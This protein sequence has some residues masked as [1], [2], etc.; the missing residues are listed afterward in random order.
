[1]W[2]LERK[3]ES[4][5]FSPR[6]IRE[7]ALRALRSLLRFFALITRS[8]KKLRKRKLRSSRAAQ[9]SLF[10]FLHHD[11]LVGIPHTFALV[12]LRRAIPANLRRHLADLLLV[13]AAHEDLRLGRRLDGHAV[14][15]IEFHRMAESQL[16]VELAALSLRT[17]PDADQIQLLL[18]TIG[19]TLHHIVYERA[20][21][22][23]HRGCPARR[24]FEGQHALFVLHFHGRVEIHRQFALGPLDP[25]LLALLVEFDALRQFDRITG[26]SGHIYFSVRPRCTALRRRALRAA[27]VNHSSRPWTCS[28]SR[29]R[30]RPVLA[31]GRKRQSKGVDPACLRG[32]VDR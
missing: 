15:H 17:V 22:A 19:H 7:R 21:G 3:T 11:A 10:G 23:G 16:E 1:M 28:R 8:S 24:G 9:S 31:A 32:A 2:R 29:Y 14:G 18:E 25:K 13:G 26:N 5:G 30:A 12:G 20:H 6:A 27:R 4:L